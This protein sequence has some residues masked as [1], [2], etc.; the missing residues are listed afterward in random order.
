MILLDSSVWID[1][2]AKSNDKVVEVL[3]TQE[4][5]AHPFVIGEL[6]CGTMRQRELF[7]SQL[8]LLPSLPMASH[9]EC[10]TLLSANRLWG[11]GLSWINVHLLASCRIAR[12]RV[13]TNDSALMLVSKRLGLGAV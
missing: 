3:D 6:A 4:V 1:H 10:M 9:T 7:L 2:L 11:I 5:V 13:W 12:V 8:A